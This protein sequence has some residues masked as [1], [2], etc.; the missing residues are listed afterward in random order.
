MSRNM[1]SI[2]KIT[3]W[4]IKKLDNRKK[5]MWDIPTIQERIYNDLNPYDGEIVEDK[6]KKVK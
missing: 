6:R 5:Y 4:D 1:I 3:N 2:E